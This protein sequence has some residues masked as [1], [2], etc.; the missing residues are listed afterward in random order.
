M[1]LYINNEGKNVKKEE[2]KKIKAFWDK[3]LEND[4]PE[5]YED[6]YPLLTHYPSGE[7][8]I[9]LEEKNMHKMTM[10]HPKLS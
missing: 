3:F 9:H 7:L 8:K 2:Y 4:Y 6:L 5:F 10:D 1:N